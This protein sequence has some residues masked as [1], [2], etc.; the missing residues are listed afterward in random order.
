M[1]DKPAQVHKASFN[2]PEISTRSPW[3]TL[4]LAPVTGQLDIKVF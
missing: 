4:T 1:I 3:A 2:A